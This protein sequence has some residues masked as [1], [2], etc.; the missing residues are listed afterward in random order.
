MRLIPVPITFADA[1]DFVAA[2][3]R[4]HDRDVSHKFSVAA[5]P[6][7]EP[8]RVVGVAIAGRPKGRG[9]DDGWNLEVTRCAVG[10]EEECKNACS[11]LY[12]AVR[13]VARELGYRK[14]Y[15][16]TLA[17]EPGTTLK[18][19]GWTPD[20]EVPGRPWDCASRPRPRTADLFGEMPKQAANEGE[21]KIRWVCVL[22]TPV[23]RRRR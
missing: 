19:A 21:D 15:T 10:S 1:N 11:F 6:A 23:R 20:A 18:A 4:H 2:H 5:A 17:S 9:L 22:S 8:E 16:Y 12:G 14:L 3:H 13:R 7:E